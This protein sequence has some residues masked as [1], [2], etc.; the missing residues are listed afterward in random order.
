MNEKMKILQINSSVMGEAGQS[1]R[2]GKR[3]IDD[4]TTKNLVADVTA[5]DLNNSLPHLTPE[6]VAANNTPE[7]ERTAAHQDALSLSDDL[8]AEIEAADLL[9]IG[10]ALYNFA[11]P[12]SLKAWIDLICR[13]R[14]TFA[15][16]EDG[17]QGLL[18]GKKAIITFA[19]GG[20]PF[21]SDIDF[22]SDYMRHILGFIGIVDVEFVAAEQHFMVADAVEKADQ[23]S[24]DLVAKL[25]AISKAA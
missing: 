5:R 19:S 1:G 10:V 21:G 15:Y 22:A 8:I 20:T 4:L 17:P 16:G 7:A 11:I 2:L 18:K 24:N 6:W 25:T 13:A 23:S 9:V 3:I 14:K 12:A